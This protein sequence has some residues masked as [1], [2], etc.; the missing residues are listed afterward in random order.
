MKVECIRVLLIEDSYDSAQLLREELMDTHSH[1]FVLEH[2]DRLSKGLEILRRGE[3]DVVLLDISLPD[4][5]GLGTFT[6]VYRH[7]PDIPILVMTNLDD[8][9]FAVKAVQEGAQDYL[10]KGRVDS[11]FLVRS[12][13]YAIERHRTLK[14][15][16]LAQLK[17]QH[18]A[19]H[20]RL[21]G[22][23]NRQLFLDILCKSV[24]R[25]SRDGNMV[26]VLFLDL[27]GFKS[28]NDNQGHL[29]G[30]LLLQNV[31]GRIKG[32]IRESDLVARVG[33]D[34][35]IIIVDSIHSV[36][37]VTRVS[38]KIVEETARVFIL[39]GQELFVTASIG[40]SLYPHDSSDMET[41]VK[42]ADFAMYIAKRQGKNNF[43]YFLSELNEKER[44]EKESG[45][46][47]V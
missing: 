38:Q 28:V 33:G 25:A 23:P 32:C 35:F 29:I 30:D 42:N 1:V 17:M 14:E 43:H 6:K 19:H 22:L 7:S 13:R 39:E 31:A 9:S 15:L 5:Q 34:E 36:R 47:A 18:M 41:L 44:V 27:D 2:A 10:V 11:N 3:I 46:R 20:D 37:N 4:S 45:K 16:K 40:I 21:T 12:I 24:A 26:A 8:E